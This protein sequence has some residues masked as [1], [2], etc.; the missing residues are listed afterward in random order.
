M[1]GRKETVRFFL[2][3]DIGTI[4]FTLLRTKKQ[5]QQ[6]RFSR[7]WPFLLGKKL[8]RYLDQTR[9]VMWTDFQADPWWSQMRET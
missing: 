6:R 5:S 8:L 9:Q 3:V 7:T 4:C 2:R 1:I